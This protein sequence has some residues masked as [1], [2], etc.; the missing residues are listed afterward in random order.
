MAVLCQ[1]Y[2]MARAGN[3]IPRL[4]HVQVVLPSDCFL[5]LRC[6]QNPVPLSQFDA[7]QQCNVTGVKADLT[8]GQCSELADT[9]ARSSVHVTSPPVPHHWAAGALDS[10][11]TR[12]V[13]STATSCKLRCASCCVRPSGLLI[14]HPSLPLS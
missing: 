3:M 5:L 10:M 4:S 6:V 11:H 8:G 14:M 2:I 13:G 1:R 12:V 9:P 7:W